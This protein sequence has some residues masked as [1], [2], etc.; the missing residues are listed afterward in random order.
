MRIYSISFILIVFLISCAPKVKKELSP[1]KKTKP[2]ISDT[3]LWG[4]K[5]AVNVRESNSAK[6]KK[7]ASIAD[8]DSVLVIRNVNGWYE[9]ILSNQQKGWIRSDLIGTKN[10]SAFRKAV[11]FSDS[12]TDNFGIKLYFD[13]NL[14]H[15]RIY[16]EFPQQF[17]SSEKNIREKTTEIIKKY[18]KDIYHGKIA[19]RILKPA[20]QDDYLTLNFEGQPNPEIKLPVI[21]FG[22]L[23]NI[24]IEG[25][26]QIKIEIIVKDKIQNNQFLNAARDMSGSFPLSFTH[27]QIN[28]I[29]NNS[30]CLFSFLE[31]SAG[32]TYKFNQCL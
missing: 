1:I 8:G 16:L 24:R 3:Y 9:I 14:Q 13:K 7:I 5:S 25:Y 12:L 15:K 22:I 21:P 10:L 19:V 23:K 17:Y 27:V 32:E 29:S 4:F 20:S 30:D 2:K 11:S 18:Q 6:S 28:F 26:T 31:D